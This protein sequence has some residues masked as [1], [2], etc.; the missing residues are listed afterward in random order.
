MYAG[1][2][3]SASTA[4][5]SQDDAAQTAPQHP[6]SSCDIVHQGDISTTSAFFQ[7]S[8]EAT[9]ASASHEHALAQ[10]LPSGSIPE[11]LT[12]ASAHIQ[13]MSQYG[14]GCGANA[15]SGEAATN[16]PAGAWPAH[17]HHAS[18]QGDALAEMQRLLLQ[19]G[20]SNLSPMEAKAVL[21]ASHHSFMQPQVPNSNAHGSNETAAAAQPEDATMQLCEPVTAAVGAGAI[22]VEGEAKAPSAPV[23]LALDDHNDNASD[24]P[25][26]KVVCGSR[27]GSPA[28]AANQRDTQCMERV[29]F[30][31]Q[32]P[33]PAR[34]VRPPHLAP[35][36][37]PLGSTWAPSVQA[38]PPLIVPEGVYLLYRCCRIVLYYCKLVLL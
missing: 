18:A 15:C 37:C 36:P 38:G 21:A 32:Y 25:P 27:K 22:P 26:R 31:P 6:Q 30:N 9:H 11:L 7:G 12:L 3:V 33:F 4:L 5:Q 8:P 2:H 20:A 23:P 24:E 29:L 35:L 28:G 16:M 1:S 34:P 13:M 17:R 10:A 19:A 14:Q